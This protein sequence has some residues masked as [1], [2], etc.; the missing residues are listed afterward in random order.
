[1]YTQ[2]WTFGLFLVTLHILCSTWLF[3]NLM[4]YLGDHSMLVT[5]AYLWKYG[6]FSSPLLLQ[7][8]LYLEYKSFHVFK[9]TVY[10]EDKFLE[11]E[12]LCQQI[13][14]FVLDLIKLSPKR[15]QFCFH[16]QC[17]RMLVSPP[18]PCQHNILYFFIFANL[19]NENG[20]LE[21]F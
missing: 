10:L 1:M 17:M 13:Y 11:V 12:F 8:K 3:F 19:M 14:I 7:T 4:M 5:V 15:L 21:W 16:Q 2:I 6:F 9:N 18:Q 20:I